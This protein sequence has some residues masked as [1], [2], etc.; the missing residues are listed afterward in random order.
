MYCGDMGDRSDHP[1]CRSVDD[2]RGTCVCVRG[3][4]VCA[5]GGDL[6]MVVPQVRGEGAQ[7]SG[8]ETGRGD[9]D[10]GAT[11]YCV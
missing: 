8:G 11:V 4:R 6:R 7:L 10:G 2:T 1:L 9:G 5:S 3:S